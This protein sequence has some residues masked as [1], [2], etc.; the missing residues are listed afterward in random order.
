MLILMIEGI[1]QGRFNRLWIEHM[2]ICEQSET[3]G[4]MELNWKKFVML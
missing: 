2:Y 1:V 4:G 3:T